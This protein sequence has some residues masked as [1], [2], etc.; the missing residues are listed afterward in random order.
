MAKLKQIS[1]RIDE[2]T[3]EK[4]DSLCFGRPYL[5]RNTVINGILK[6]VVEHTGSWE[7][8]RMACD[9]VKGYAI[10]LDLL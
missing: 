2:Q 1:A 5:K 4:I 6:A 10:R 8:E 9:Q 7:I 3:L